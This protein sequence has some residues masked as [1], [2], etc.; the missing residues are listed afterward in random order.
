MGVL[1]TWCRSSRC[2]IRF[3]SAIIAGWAYSMPSAPRCRSIIVSARNSKPGKA[4]VAAR[5]LD[6]HPRFRAWCLARWDHEQL[7]EVV[8][9]VRRVESDR[10]EVARRSG[11]RP[12][13]SVPLLAPP[14]LDEATR[15]LLRRDSVTGGMDDEIGVLRLDPSAN[16]IGMV[17]GGREAPDHHV[18]D[19]VGG[20]L[21]AQPGEE[22]AGVDG[23]R[24]QVGKPDTALQGAAF[25]LLKPCAQL[26]LLTLDDRPDQDELAIQLRSV[27]RALKQVEVTLARLESDPRR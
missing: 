25:R 4:V 13:L 27:R 11:C 2:E 8:V 1:M 5:Q 12:R 9:V 26:A 15:D 7:H 21:V 16:L 22:G 6:A 24:A 20:Q 14:A 18:V 3:A 23:A 19:H 17:L 10:W